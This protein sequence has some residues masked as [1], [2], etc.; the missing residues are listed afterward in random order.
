MTGTSIVVR[1]AEEFLEA[2]DEYRRQQFDIPSRA[3]VLR[4]LTRMALSKAKSRE[5]HGTRELLHCDECDR[6]VVLRLLGSG[7]GDRLRLAP[8]SGSH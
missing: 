7:A 1:C 5:G 2:L 4:R 3:E 6:R 8:A